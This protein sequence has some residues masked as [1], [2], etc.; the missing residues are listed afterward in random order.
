MDDIVKLY[1]T[2]KETI[3]NFILCTT[4]ALIYAA[5]FYFL[6]TAESSDLKGIFSIII[7]YF[8]LFGLFFFVT[9]LLNSGLVVLA[10][11]LENEDFV[12]NAYERTRVST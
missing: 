4:S 8:I 10:L 2:S 9:A 12:K 6:I 5:F 7:F 3:Y 11:I 1:R